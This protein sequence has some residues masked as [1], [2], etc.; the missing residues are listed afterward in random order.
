MT[1]QRL[2]ITELAAG[3]VTA[4]RL[5]LSGYW[6]EDAGFPIGAGVEVEVVEP[7]RLVVTRQDLGGSLP[8]LLPLVWVPVERL[9]AIEEA[10]EA[11]MSEV[12]RA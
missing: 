12:A 11:A 10:G 2:R 3:G 1:E 9:A 5:E 8:G 6:L 4:P 7:G